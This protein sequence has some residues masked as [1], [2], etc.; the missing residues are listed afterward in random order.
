VP[1]ATSPLFLPS[2]ARFTELLAD[3]FAFVAH[4]FALVGLGRPQVADLGGDLA[5]ALLVDPVDVNLV[6]A[7]DVNAIPPAPR[8]STGCE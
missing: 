2:L 1:C 8:T 4:A 5:D 6:G 3:D 7:L